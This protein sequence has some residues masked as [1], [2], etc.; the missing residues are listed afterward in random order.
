MNYWQVLQNIIFEK[1]RANNIE[2]ICGTS[3]DFLQ[4]AKQENLVFDWIY[5]DPARRDDVQKKVFLLED[6]QPNMIELWNLYKNVGK[7]WLL[8]TAPL[9]D[10]QLVLNRLNYVEKVEIVALQNECKEVLYQL[11]SYGEK[12]NLEKVQI[13]TTNLH[14]N[15]SE[16]KNSLESN[17]EQFSFFLEEEK[18]ITIDY[19]IKNEI[20]DFLYEP[21]VAVLKAGAFKS[22]SKKYQINKLSANTHLYTSIE[23]KENFIGKTFKIVEV[24]TYSKKE[25]KR[26]FGKG[27]FNIV[28]RNFPISVKELRKQFSILEGQNEFLFFTTLTSNSVDEKV[29]LKVEK[30]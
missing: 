12:S 29:V 26:K 10:I 16:I 1:L 21:N 2:V 27:F 15:K 24:L 17:A 7:K 4:K 22:I 3:E 14:L 18:G 9:L 6:C 23:L 11:N 13:N 30:I 28:T 19:S 25:V 20:L 8:K 5:L